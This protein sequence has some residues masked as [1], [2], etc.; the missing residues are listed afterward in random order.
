M[1]NFFQTENS[2]KIKKAPVVKQML[3]LMWAIRH[4]V[5]FAERK[6]LTYALSRMASSRTCLPFADVLSAHY[7]PASFADGD[8]V[9]PFRGTCRA[10]IALQVLVFPD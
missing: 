8:I 3:F 10:L 6:G 4:F 2:F 9:S 7:R 1:D 5:P